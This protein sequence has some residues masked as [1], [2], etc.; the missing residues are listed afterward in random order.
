MRPCTIALNM[1]CVHGSLSLEEL[2][3]YGSANTR[4]VAK[5]NAVP[6]GPFLNCKASF[7]A[8]QFAQ[9]TV[10]QSFWQT[11]RTSTVSLY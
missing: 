11:V 4:K 1:I 5:L 3:D 9:L 8:R 6:I 10:A 2:R 7:P